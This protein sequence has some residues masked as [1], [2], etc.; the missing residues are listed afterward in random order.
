MG[1][2]GIGTFAQSGGT[3]N[4]GT[5]YINAASS[6]NLSGN[7]ALLATYETVSAATFTQSGG[8]NSAT[9]T[10]GFTLSAGTYNLNG[11][12]LAVPG[13][14]GSGV[15]NFGGGTLAAN[16]P[17]FSTTQ[18]MTLTGGNGNVNTGSYAVA[19][20]GNLSGSGGLIASGG[21]TLALAGSNTYTGG[22]TIS[23]GT[24]VLSN[25]SPAV[26]GG[27]LT[28]GPNGG[29]LF[30]SNSGALTTFYLN[31]LAGSGSVSLA[32]NFSNPP[33]NYPIALSIGGSG[34]SSTYGGVLS[35]AGSLSKTGSG[36]LVLCGAN[37]YTG[38]TSIAGGGLKLDFSQPGAPSNYIINPSD[39]APLIL[40]G[41]TLTLQENGTRP[42][43]RGSTA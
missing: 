8:T 34:S 9:G 24:L 3:N 22:T 5:L 1:Y 15:F 14:S 23:G 7:G 36:T 41:G 27:S 26:S 19:L 29:L 43:A 20:A 31:G 37:T 6:Y 12:V 4:L 42:T 16:A 18:A 25:N 13:I 32:D 38:S 30:N 11:G 17:G 40:A 35:G 10:S 28:I 33:T 39:S 2:N 21:G